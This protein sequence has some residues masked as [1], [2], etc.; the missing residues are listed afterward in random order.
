MRQETKWFK[1]NCTCF[2]EPIGIVL[3]KDVVDFVSRHSC[4]DYEIKG[5]LTKTFDE[6]VNY[7]Y[8]ASERICPIDKENR[9]V[10][11]YMSK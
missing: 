2:T 6:D 4:S 5:Q 10:F 11:S 8:T 7:Y 1:V 3:W 9:N